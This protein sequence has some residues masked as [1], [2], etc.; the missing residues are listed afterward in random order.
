MK[1][2]LDKFLAV[3]LTHP[4]H[5][6]I[7]TWS[8]GCGFRL[9]VKLDYPQGVRVQSLKSHAGIGTHIDAPSHFIEGGNNI[10]D[11]P[12]EHLIVP[13]LV[14]DISEKMDPDL[15]IEPEDIEAFEQEHGP[16]PSGSAFFAYTGWGRYWKDGVRYRNPDPNGVMH[17][18]G[19][20][21]QAAQ[22]LVQRGVHGIGI[23]TLSP[24]GSNNG[25]KA[26]YPVHLEILGSGGYIIENVANLDQVPPKGA[27]LVALPPRATDATESAARA[28]A[29]IFSQS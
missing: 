11:I 2:V 6:G 13:L 23:D 17:F 3:D 25:S 27:Y 1:R 29:L 9:E 5:E 4:L 18:P 19:F 22:L 15:F 24:D 10:G 28:I 8:G 7:P 26:L 20:S 16:I 14:L 21:K 12:L